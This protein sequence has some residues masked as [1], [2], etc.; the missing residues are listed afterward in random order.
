MKDLK[1]DYLAVPGHK[2]LLGPQGTGILILRD[3]EELRPTTLGGG[4]VEWVRGCEYELLEPP[5]CFEAGIPTSQESSVSGDLWNT[6]AR[7]ASRT[8]KSTL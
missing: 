6:S 5:A 1:C 8:L 4:A 2:G 7:W 3:P